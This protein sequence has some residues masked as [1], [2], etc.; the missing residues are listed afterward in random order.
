MED[1]DDTTSSAVA[2]IA[3]A[4]ATNAAAAASGDNNSRKRAASDLTDGGGGGVAAAAV[5]ST[6]NK[7]QAT[8]G[9][10]NKG[11]DPTL[12]KLQDNYVDLSESIEIVGKDEAL[13]PLAS[14]KGSGSSRIKTICGVAIV[15][16][17]Q[18]MVYRLSSSLPPKQ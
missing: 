11:E 13:I 1:N 17:L 18:N 14:R 12:K 4:A 8:T 16:L 10:T 15:K 5:A 6:S 7:K 2:A 3:A 9:S